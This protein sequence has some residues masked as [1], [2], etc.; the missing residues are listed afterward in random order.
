[1]FQ[2]LRL[3][4]LAAA[5]PILLTAAAQPATAAPCITSK[6]AFETYKQ[7]LAHDARAQGVSQRG[8]EALRAARLSDLTWRFESNPASQ[9]GVSQGDPATFLAK[10]SGGSAQGFINQARGQLGRNAALFESIERGYGVPGSILVTIWGLETSWGGYL[11]QTPI[12][13]GAVTLAS[14]C[15]RHPRF[16]EHAVAAL[17]LVD[18]GVVD[19]RTRG[20]PSGELGH[21]QFLS[22]NWLRFGVDAD[23][24]GRADPY[25]SVDALASAANMLRQHGWRAGQPF[26]E[27]TANFAVLSAWNDSGNYQRAIAYAAERIGN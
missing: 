9:T 27:G 22:G 1:M 12:V 23:G 10:R 5:L 13:G 25:D 15:R 2:R 21:M 20:G 7:N 18:R 26:G 24:D 3:A 16:E 6:A 8:L 4:A 14:Y 17:K 19:A 11:G